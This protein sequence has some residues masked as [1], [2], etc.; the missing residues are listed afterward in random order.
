MSDTTFDTPQP[1]T[2]R[3]SFAAGDLSVDAHDTAQS[4]VSISPDRD[5]ED[6]WAFVSECVVD[7]RGDELVVQ[8]P[9]GKGWRRRTPALHVV[10]TLPSD[11]A[12]RVTVAS[13]D[14]RAAGR[15]GRVEITT[16]SG[17]IDVGEAT[18]ELSVKTASG[19][20]TAAAVGGQV[21]VNSASGDI[22]LGRCHG[23]VKVNAASGD[24]T[25][26]EARGSVSAKTASGDTTIRQAHSGKV[27]VNTA[28]GDVRVGVAAGTGVYLDLTSL[29]GDTTTNLDM[30]GDQPA[31]STE[32]SLTIRTLSG[33][34]HVD[35]SH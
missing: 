3:A 22:E 5:D 35:R 1:V 30:E 11:S 24:V 12:L 7:L 27:S 21:K 34:I 32:L 19:D 15:Y 23:D 26:A 9:E 25:V 20:L 31:G 13:A 6:A 14:V 33:D 29:S 10:V 16:A 2:L 4:Q 28:S 8:A 18:G 17:D